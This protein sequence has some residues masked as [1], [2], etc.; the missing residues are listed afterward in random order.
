MNHNQVG[1]IN[2]LRDPKSWKICTFSD[3]TGS[4]FPVW[5]LS[6][7]WFTSCSATVSSRGRAARETAGIVL[8]RDC[9]IRSAGSPCFSYLHKFSKSCLSTKIIKLQPD[10]THSM[11]FPSRCMFYSWIFMRIDPWPLVLTTI[12]AV[13]CPP[14][15]ISN[16]SANTSDFSYPAVVSVS[17]HV[18]F[19]FSSDMIRSS[20]VIRCMTNATWSS[21]PSG[22]T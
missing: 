20:A 19:V 15:S 14:I 10:V 9:Q 5:V 12:A 7:V 4:L 2:I 1:W 13:I 8:V 17:C 18:G 6:I 3:Y 16:A 11:A 22:C 21:L